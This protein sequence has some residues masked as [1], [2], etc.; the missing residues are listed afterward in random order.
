MTAGTEG[1]NP[2]M[3]KFVAYTY[4]AFW[5]VI[6]GFGGFASMV[7]GAPEPVMRGIAVLGSWSPTLVLLALRRRLMPGGSVRDFYAKAFAGRIRIG[8]VLG[9]P[10]LVFGLFAAAAATSA[11]LGGFRPGAGISFEPGAFLG[12]AA[13]MLFLG[14]SGEESAWRGYLR[15]ALE[16][17]YGF[18]KGNILLGLV[19]AFWHAPLWVLASDF[20]GLEGLLFAGANVIVLTSL[21]V[22]LGILMRS[23][24]NLLV[25]FWTH[26]CFNLSLSLWSGGIGL[27]AALSVAYPAAAAILAAAYRIRPESPGARDS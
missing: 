10:V 9:I 7:L 24:D 1:T 21:T 14:P 20:R 12:T 27:F 15:P 11:M 17:R 25:A 2:N 16:S 13:L 23:C 4:L 19:W 18:L 6:L 5:A 22:I 26:Y 8:T 3:W